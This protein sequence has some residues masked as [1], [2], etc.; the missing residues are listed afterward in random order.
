VLSQQEGG[1]HVHARVDML[2]PMATHAYVSVSMAPVFV[3]C[4]LLLYRVDVQVAGDAGLEVEGDAV[5]QFFA[6]ESL[7]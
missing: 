1:C 3:L 2:G 4:D 7:L 5:A 6:G